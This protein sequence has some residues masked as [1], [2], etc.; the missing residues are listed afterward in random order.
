MYNCF[1]LFQSLNCKMQPIMDQSTTR[2]HHLHIAHND[3]PNPAHENPI[4]EISNQ[5]EQQNPIHGTSNKRV[6]ENPIQGISNQPVHHS[7]PD[8]QRLTSLEQKSQAP[9]DQ[10]P[11]SLGDSCTFWWW[12]PFVEWNQMNIQIVSNDNDDDDDVINGCKDDNYL[13][14]MCFNHQFFFFLYFLVKYQK[15]GSDLV[16]EVLC[17]H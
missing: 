15:P 12:S 14:Q 2:L 13:N 3:Q 7:L 6:H 1:Q 4:Q 8:S 11:V 9:V 5:R 10:N 17:K 16:D